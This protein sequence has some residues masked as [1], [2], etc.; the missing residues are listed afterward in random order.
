MAFKPKSAGKGNSG[1]F[2]TRN[3]PTPRS[4]S[5]KARV[6]LI[7][8]LGDQDREDFEDEKTGETKP[9]KPCQQVV[10]FADLVADVVDYGGEIGKQQYRMLLNKS[11]QGKVQGVNFTTTPPK[12]AKGNLVAG[13]PWALHPQNLLTKLAKATGTEEIIPEQGEH[14]LDIS[15]LMNKPF[16]CTVNVTETEAKNGK[17][18]ADGNTIVYKNVNFGGAALI[19]EDDDGNPI[20]IAEL[21]QPARCVT[22]ENATV[23]DIKLIRGSIIKQIKLA[24][25][26]PGS[27]MQKAIQ[28]YEA[29]AAKGSSSSDEAE[30]APAKEEAKKPAAKKQAKKPAQEE[31][32][33]AAPF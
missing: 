33:D 23:E 31:D 22:F 10:V 8:D 12:D 28:E 21:T 24:N 18:D 26:Y 16:M 32:D 17:K 4:G 14:G 27:Q 19:P 9:Q 15:R 2:E 6:S 7:I 5:R 11:F 25:D 3:Y 20:A 13:K 30:E 1:D 29:Q